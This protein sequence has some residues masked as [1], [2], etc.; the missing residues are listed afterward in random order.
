MS[1]MSEQKYDFLEDL[2]TIVATKWEELSETDKTTTTQITE[3]DNDYL[4]GIR[5]SPEYLM[6]FIDTISEFLDAGVDYSPYVL[7][8][9]YILENMTTFLDIHDDLVEMF[10]VEVYEID[11]QKTNLDAQETMI[12][13]QFIDLCVQEYTRQ[14]IKEI[15]PGK[16]TPTVK[17]TIYW[18]FMLTVMVM[19]QLERDFVRFFDE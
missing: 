2:Y 14:Y 5:E 12:R 7:S 6:E 4:K 16:L 11:G 3:K 9:R 15:V 10:G 18:V 1:E 17:N 13:N 8:Y 19:F